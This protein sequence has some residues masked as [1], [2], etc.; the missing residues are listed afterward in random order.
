MLIPAIQRPQRRVRLRLAV[1]LVAGGVVLLMVLARLAGAQVQAQGH[2]HAAEVPQVTPPAVPPAGPV[3]APARPLVLDNNVRLHMDMSPALRATP[4]DSARAA[5]VARE[6]RTALIQ[7]RDTT[8]AVADGYQMFL[9][10]V[11]EQKVYHFTNS[12]RAVQEAFRFNPARPTSLLYRKAPDGKFE[13][14]GAMYTAPKRF[15]ID[16][17]DARVPLSIARW[18]RHV[19]WCVPKRGATQRWLERQNGEPVFGPESPIATRDACDRVGGDFR[20]S[21]FGWMLHANVFEGDDPATIW[22][23]DHAKHDAHGMM[24]M[25]GM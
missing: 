1:L 15:G 14:I 25:D 13:L 12:W 22:G 11:K 7:Y 20:A 16:K 18:H 5:R 17:L 6:L 9:P 19:N 2:A 10:R 4:A 3:P 21:M 23:D 8:A 24:K